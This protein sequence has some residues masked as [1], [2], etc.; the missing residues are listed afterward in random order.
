[1]ATSSSPATPKTA[2]FEPGSHVQVAPREQTSADIKSGLYY[3]HYAN[4]YGTI[5]KLY[6]EEASV[7]VDRDSLPTEVRARHEEGEKAMRQ[8]WLDGLSEEARNRLSAREKEFGLNYAVL[9]SVND[10]KPFDPSKAPKPAAPA[11]VP[12]AVKQEAKQA[13]KAAAAIDMTTGQSGLAS[14]TRSADADEE[15][16]ADTDG[17][18]AAA[19]K[20][21]SE[22]EL[23]AAEAAFLAERARATKRG[24]AG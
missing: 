11:P 23:A 1:M 12:A 8:K 24:S 2:K 17:G 3:P 16:G 5:L 19:A 13:A 6:G 22:D 10:L 20:R 9:V 15:E 7:L 14:A 21:V 18:A 4:L